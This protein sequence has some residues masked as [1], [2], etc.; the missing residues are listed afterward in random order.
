MQICNWEN[1][2]NDIKNLFQSLE[3]HEK[4]IDPFSIISITEKVD[5]QKRASEIFSNYKFP[6]QL[7]N[8]INSDKNNLKTRLGY[9]SPDF[10]DHP[11]LHL[12][13]DVFKNHNKNKFEIFAFSFGPR[14]K[15]EMTEQVKKYFN[16]FID[17]NDKSDEE[18]AMLSR[19]MGIDIAIDLCGF[20]NFNRAGIFSH[21]A[22]PLQ[23]NFLGYPSTMG[24]TFIDYLI[25]DRIVIPENQKL[26]YSENIAYLPNCY[27]PNMAVKNISKTKITRNEE[28]LPA[29]AFVFCNF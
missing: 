16:E 27:Q 14:K 9:F 7:E 13:F 22:A 5:H 12:I 23:V 21:R 10:C 4:I 20:T 11:V 25:A 19:K 1:Y 26:N 24:S 8:K 3:K 29:D 17:I 2:E 15:D 6:K 18:V 28:G